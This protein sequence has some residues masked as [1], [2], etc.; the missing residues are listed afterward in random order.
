MNYLPLH[1]TETS[2]SLANYQ[3]IRE[4]NFKKLKFWLAILAASLQ[5]EGLFQLLCSLLRWVGVSMTEILINKQATWDWEELVAQKSKKIIIS[6]CQ[7]CLLPLAVSVLSSST[8]YRK[9]SF[10]HAEVILDCFKLK[11][12]KSI[13]FYV[14]IMKAHL[15]LKFLL[16]LMH[17]YLVIIF[18][19]SQ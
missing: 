9:H 2:C 6:M 14:L 13:W 12:W 8:G 10:E 16:L 4:K 18:L 15:I 11:L 1:Q 17:F 3:P 7:L 19:A 5:K